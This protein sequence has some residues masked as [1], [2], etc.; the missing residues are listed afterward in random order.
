MQLLREVSLLVRLSSCSLLFHI[1]VY[2]ILTALGSRC[3]YALE[4]KQ[5][6]NGRRTNR[7]RTVTTMLRDGVQDR[8]LRARRRQQVPALKRR[9]SHCFLARCRTHVRA[10]TFNL[11]V[12]PNYD[13]AYTTSKEKGC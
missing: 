12:L 13:S 8:S 10:R 7:C 5:M 2:G 1:C 4:L 11:G 3:A 9:T 6:Q